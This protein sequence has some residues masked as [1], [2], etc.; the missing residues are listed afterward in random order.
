MSENIIS[1]YQRYF[2]VDMQYRHGS[3]NQQIGKSR[4]EF[5]LKI[6]GRFGMTSPLIIQ[7]LYGI[8]KAQALVHLN[9][10]V[11]NDLLEVVPTHRSPDERVYI[12]SRSGALYAEELTGMP[13]YFRSTSQPELRVNLNTLYHDLIMQFIILLGMPQSSTGNAQSQDIWNGF[14]TDTEVRRLSKSAKWRNVDAIV[15][16]SDG[17]ITAVEM[18]HSFKQLPT[19]KAI[20]LQYLQDLN[21]GYY[22]KVMLFSQKTEVLNDMKRINA[23]IIEFLLATKSPERITVQDAAKLRQALVYRTKYCEQI[24]LRFYG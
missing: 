24:R 8:T 11:Q 4:R 21:N 3:N 17:S 13:I 23:N 22:Q 2:A 9:K 7:W 12:L 5:T 10:L 19:R 16:E 15:H 18:E 1:Q 6:V 20:L 14:V